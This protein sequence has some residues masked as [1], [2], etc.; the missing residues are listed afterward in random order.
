[1]IR[2]PPRSTLFPYTTLF[3]SPDVGQQYNATEGRSGRE[4]SLDHWPPLILHR[5][6]DLGVAVARQVH[7][8][9][10]LRR[11]LG[12][13]ACQRHTEEGQEAGPAR[14]L[15]HPRQVLALQEGVQQRGL[16]D[17]GA[18]GEGDLGKVSDGKLPGLRRAGDKLR[19]K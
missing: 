15:A 10:F 19:G 1:M 8:Q 17:I 11:A 14:R 4:V 9:E 13:T 12:S 2:R 5:L 16:A 6:R 7:E 3:R 18:P